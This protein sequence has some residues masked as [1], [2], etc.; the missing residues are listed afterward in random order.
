MS[1]MFIC[2]LV[3]VMVLRWLVWFVLMVCVLRM[4]EVI[5]MESV[6]NCM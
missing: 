6:G 1:M 5:V 4:D 3:W 2:R